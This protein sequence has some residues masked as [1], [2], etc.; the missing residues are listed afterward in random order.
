MAA[1]DGRGARRELPLRPR[2]RPAHAGRQAGV[3]CQRRVDHGPRRR[4]HYP[5]LAY[6]AAKGAIVNFTR[7][8]ACEWAPSSVRVNA[9]A[10]T[11]ARTR[12]TEALLA[13]E[14]MAQHLLDDTP[15]GRFVEPEEVAAGILFLA[16]DAAS[17]ITGHICR[18]TAGG[19]PGSVAGTPNPG[20]RV[21]RGRARIA[22]W[23]SLL[24][25]RTPD[26]GRER[27]AAP[28]AG[29]VAGCVSPRHG[30][31]GLPV[32]GFASPT[33]PGGPRRELRTGGARPGPG[34]AGRRRPR[35]GLPTRAP[36]C[37]CWG[38]TPAPAR[39]RPGRP[40]PSPAAGQRP[41]RAS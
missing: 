27:R 10:P 13:D 16:G 7:G 8:L 17:M 25:P 26:G 30:Y 19:S 28:A 20:S 36:R 18:S 32:C 39:W 2:G 23:A 41:A 5:N 21:P 24:R 34:A 14:D 31:R 35:L 11:W 22:P 6:H 15:L 12:L 38:Q 3:G 40:A 4:V 37:P 1:G 33:G 9:V 29:R